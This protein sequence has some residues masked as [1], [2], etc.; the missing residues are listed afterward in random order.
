[1]Q[2]FLS[3]LHLYNKLCKLGKSGKWVKPEVRN[4]RNWI[5]VF[6]I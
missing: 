4:E 5:K 6:V 1:M 2:R 3:F